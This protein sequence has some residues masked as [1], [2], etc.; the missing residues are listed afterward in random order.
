MRTKERR[1]LKALGF[2]GSHSRVARWVRDGAS[3][4]GNCDGLTKSRVR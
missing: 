4:G 1:E 3:L 2:H